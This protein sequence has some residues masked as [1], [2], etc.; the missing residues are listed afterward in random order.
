MCPLVEV[1]ANLAP[2]CNTKVDWQSEKLTMCWLP[3]ARLLC[4]TQQQVETSMLSL[5]SLPVHCLMCLHLPTHVLVVGSAHITVTSQKLIFQ[6]KLKNCKWM[7]IPPS[8]IHV[9]IGWKALNH[10]RTLRWKG[11]NIGAWKWHR[12]W[13][14]LKKLKQIHIEFFL[15][16]CWWSWS[17]WQSLHGVNTH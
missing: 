15:Q 7:V 12:E 4:Y 2:I 5:L 3:L 10:Q 17:W 11:W 9:M 8:M 13:L 14:L 6:L 1:A 16:N